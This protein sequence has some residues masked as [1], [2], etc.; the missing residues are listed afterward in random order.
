[1]YRTN[2]KDCGEDLRLNPVYVNTSRCSRCRSCYNKHHTNLRKEREANDPELRANRLASNRRKTLNRYDLT[3]D[4]YNAKFVLQ[5]GGCAI[6]KHAS[7]KSLFVDHSHDTGV[8]RDLLCYS[9]N[10]LLGYVENNE[11][12]VIAAIEYLKRHDKAIAS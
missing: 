7:D 8:V 5:L 10:T 1:M 6:C 9:C 2:C 12:L 3:L 11:D 4:Q